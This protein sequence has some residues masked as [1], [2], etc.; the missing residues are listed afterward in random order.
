MALVATPH[1][2]KELAREL[3][4]VGGY[5]DP[6]DLLPQE[7]R[8]RLYEMAAWVVDDYVA[9]DDFHEGCMPAEGHYDAV[10]DAYEDGIEDG[11][12][13]AQEAIAALGRT[14]TGPARAALR[15]AYRAAEGTESG[16]AMRGRI[17]AYVAE[18][19]RS[20]GRG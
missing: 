7:E 14:K 20:D 13:S 6:F 9:G 18:R 11:I 17:A 16:E 3:A 10:G 4:R 19:K 2:A 1:Y 12:R 8:D 15:E 5:E